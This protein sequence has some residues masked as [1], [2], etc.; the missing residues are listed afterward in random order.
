MIDVGFIGDLHLGHPAMAKARGFDDLDEYHEYIIK[1]YNSVLHP[2][3]LVFLLGDTTFEKPTYYH[4]LDRLLGRKISIN[5]NHDLPKDALELLKYVEGI[6]G[7]MNYKG[8][9]LTHIPAERK[10]MSR[11]RINIHAHLHE[12]IVKQFI[13]EPMEA[14]V[15]I[16]DDPKYFCCSWE[17]LK[18]VPISL[19]QIFATKL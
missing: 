15:T 3:S 16:L 9:L 7:A 11:F 5:G 13:Y 4:L 1:Q 6:G 2:R 10:E 19:E 8:C 12:G 18:G 17:R 14:K